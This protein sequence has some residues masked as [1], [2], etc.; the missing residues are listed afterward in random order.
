MTQCKYSWDFVAFSVFP[1]SFK[2]P[3][4]KKY[5][6][7][8]RDVGQRSSIFKIPKLFFFVS[9]KPFDLF[10]F[11][12]SL[13]TWINQMFPQYLQ[14]RTQQLTHHCKLCDMHRAKHSKV[15]AYS[16]IVWGERTCTGLCSAKNIQDV[17]FVETVAAGANFL[18]IWQKRGCKQRL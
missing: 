14:E 9:I 8:R 10:F 18:P 12:L 2:E 16:L 11:F 4:L 3:T 7:S 1:L 15:L 5:R 6:P 17:D 13:F